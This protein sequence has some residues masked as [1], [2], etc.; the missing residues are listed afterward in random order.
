VLHV[1]AG[2]H[3]LHVANKALSFSA[4]GDQK[5]SA[6]SIPW[7]RMQAGDIVMSLSVGTEQTGLYDPSFSH[8]AVFLGPDERGAALL[9]EAVDSKA[10]QGGPE[11]RSVP[12]EQS[13]PYHYAARAAIFRPID[14]LTGTELAKT[15][16]NLRGVV[17]RG[18][19]Y[20]AQDD[21][22][23]IYQLW[24]MWDG[25]VNRARDEKKFQQT[26]DRLKEQFRSGER[27]TCAGLVWWAFWAGTNGRLDLSDPYRVSLGGHL[28]G[29][30]SKKF[31]D[32]VGP[33]LPMPDSFYLSGKLRE[34]R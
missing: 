13:H 24:S 27:F 6:I 3:E 4:R 19:R 10:A 31:L 14:P 29:T 18:L 23:T 5:A 17:N 1:T 30:L 26:L 28:A 33:L 22:A 25:R 15:L 7:E 20:W 2:P 8:A 9:A 12:V 21:F 16:A 11:I 34:V 32:R